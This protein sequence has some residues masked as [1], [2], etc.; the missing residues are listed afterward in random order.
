MTK[1]ELNKRN[2]PAGRNVRARLVTEVEIPSY[3]FLDSIGESVEIE[4]I[5]DL[6]EA[7]NKWIEESGD[8]YWSWGTLLSEQGIFDERN[9]VDLELEWA[10]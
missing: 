3:V 5:E 1:V 7:T 10:D 2:A 6:I 9:F 8:P 4:T